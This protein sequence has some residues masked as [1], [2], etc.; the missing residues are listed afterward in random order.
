MMM[1]LIQHTPMDPTL[2][3]V[4]LSIFF[5]GFG[6]VISSRIYFFMEQQYAL[7]HKRPLY[8]NLIL[9]RN[10][11]SLQQIDLIGQY[12][13]FYNTLS[14]KEQSVFQH[15]VGRFLK[16]KQ[17]VGREGFEVT[18]KHKTLIAATA[19]M[20][21]F[22]FRQYL[23]EL[24]DVIIIYPKAFYSY[25][26]DSYHKGEMNPQVK[27]IVFSWEDF[28][29][30]F[31]EPT[32]SVNLGFHE[33]GHAIHLNSFTRGDVSSLIFNDAFQRLLN[34]LKDNEPIRQALI[35]SNYFRGYAFTNQFEFA[36]VLM[37]HFMETP[38]EFKTQFPDVYSY[39]KQMLNYNFAGY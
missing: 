37:E 10:K 21:T 35:T 20:L 24:I 11:L 34:Y 15:R 17:F 23:I 8:R 25:R 2:K 5:I 27:T 18:D 19:V 38:S 28:N 39:V 14:T 1:P 22:G 16:S 6:L 31:E 13:P 32:D 33:F 30:G 29:R 12:F 3:L 9:F 7:K 4:L 36:A 26:N